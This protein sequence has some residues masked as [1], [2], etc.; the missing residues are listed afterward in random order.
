MRLQDFVA[1]ANMARLARSEQYEIDVRHAVDWLVERDELDRL[2]Q[3]DEERRR[4]EDFLSRH[5]EAGTPVEI[6]PD[7]L[8]KA[9]FAR[10]PFVVW[11][12]PIDG[13]DEIEVLLL[14]L[15]HWKARR[16]R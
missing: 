14:R 1:D 2:I 16:R 15:F 8:R 6:G 5:P 12:V 11:Y 9:I 3:F 7:V 13:G 4:L 10:A